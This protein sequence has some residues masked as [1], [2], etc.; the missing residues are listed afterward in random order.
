MKT[1]FMPN[2]IQSSDKLRIDPEQSRIGQKTYPRDVFMHLLNTIAL[3]VGVFSVLNLVFDYINAAYPDPLNPYYDPTS[4]IRWSLSLFIIIFGVFVWTSWFIEKDLVKNPEKNDL[5]IR[6]WLIY[7]TV[8]LAALLLIGDLVALIYNFLGG[9]LTTPFILKIL[10]VLAVG[11]VVFWYYLN[12]LKKKPGEFSERDRIKT[13]T[14]LAVA[15]IVIIYGF[16]VVGSP[17]RQRLATF[18]IR[19][20]GDLEAIQGS[21]INY[22]VQKAKLPNSLDDL[23]DSIS[24]FSPPQDPQT[25]ESYVYNK[26]G[27]L[28]FELCAN[29]NLVYDKSQSTRAP[30]PP[31]YPAY[32]YDYKNNNWNHR[33]GR[34]CFERIIDPELYRPVKTP[35]K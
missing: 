29:F 1:N 17:F 19:K 21:I 32:N 31:A 33:A 22:W 3:Y 24:G 28:S 11:G 34:I 4:S 14:I 15:L 18:D 9:E 26:T 20:V 5:R 23:R 27:D 10:A 25:N 8:F 16:F 12:N 6:R 13:W 35:V 2:H 30:L 7:L